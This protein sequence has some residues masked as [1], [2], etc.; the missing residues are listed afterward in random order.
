MI[1]INKQLRKYFI[2]ISIISVVFITIVS[3]LSMNYFFANYIKESRSRDDL[4]L[5]QYIEQLYNEN[6]VLDSRSL[7]NI[8]HYSYSEGIEVKIKNMNNE[9][10]WESGRPNTM[11]HGMMSRMMGNRFYPST[12]VSYKDYPM[13]YRGQQVATIVIGRPQSIIGTAE[14]RNFVYTINGVYIAAFLFSII[15]ASILSLHVSKKFLRPIYRIKENAKLIENEKYKQLLNVETNTLELNDLSLSIKELAEKLEYQDALRKRLTSDIA[16]ELRT[17]L[18]T[19]Q[20]HIEAFMDGIWEPT[21]ERL[22]SIHDEITR[23]TKLIKDLSDLSK[24][25][26][27]EIKLNMENV[28][29][30][31]LL[32]NVVD[33]FEPLFISKDIKIIKDIQHNVEMMGDADRLNQIFINLLSNAY[34]YTNEKG[35]VTTK[36]TEYNGKISIVIEDT[37]VGIAKEDIVHIFERFYRGDASRSRETGGAGIGLTITKALIEAHDGTIKIESEIGKGTRVSVTFPLLR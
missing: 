16:H 37:G 6:E 15:L 21:Q 10:I 25:E 2:L 30:S 31:A 29:L 12:K 13:M 9:I 3:N 7:M 11:M 34:K 5:I 35:S 17:P 32:N 4:K 14:D 33:N 24:I 19:L 22:M 28:N 23:L 36:L 1:N 20:S 18:A 26:S 8:M 27:E